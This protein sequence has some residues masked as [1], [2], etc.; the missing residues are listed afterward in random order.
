MKPNLILDC[1]PGGDDAVAILLAAKHANLHA[2][3]TVSGNVSLAYTTRNAL[4]LLEVIGADIP[5]HSGASRPLKCEPVYAEYV[6]G[7]GGFGDVKLPQPTREVSSQ[8]AVGYLIESSRTIDGLW[9]AA[10]GPLTNI[11]MAIEQDPDWVNRIE[12]LAIMGG[13][14]DSGNITPMA[15][16]NIWADPEAARIVF[17]SGAA[18]KLCGLN[19]TRQLQTDDDILMRLT[20]HGTV[21]QLVADLFAGL[22]T[23]L[24]VLTGER[25]AALHDPCAIIALT[26]PELIDFERLPVDV[27]LCGELTRGMTVIDQRPGPAPASSRVEVGM[28]IDSD[29]AMQLIIDTLIRY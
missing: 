22:H 7:E 29:S 15:E 8:D 14:T 18:I 12:G 3:T 6:H 24:S 28:T 5:V 11:A 21:A 2:I 17:N 20:G 27:E 4:S 16:F 13:G 25:R 23:R 9:V 1:D 19:L 26:H 10:V